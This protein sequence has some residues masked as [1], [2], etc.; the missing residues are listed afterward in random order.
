MC[1]QQEITKRAAIKA[2][3]K[4]EIERINSQKEMC[5]KFLES[6][7]KENMKQ[8]ESFHTQTMAGLENIRIAIDTA[9]KNSDMDC[10]LELIKAQTFFME[11]NNK[12]QLALME[13]VNKPLVEINQTN[14]PF[15]YLE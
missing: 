9:S 5:L 2:Q 7:H 15:G 4:V 8:I 1:K 14:K 11:M 13:Q 10:L 6:N 3:M 12:S